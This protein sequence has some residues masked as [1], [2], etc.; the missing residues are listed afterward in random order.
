MDILHNQLQAVQRSLSFVSTDPIDWK[1]Y[2][3]V[4]AWSVTLFESY[5][6]C[7]VFFLFRVFHPFIIF[8]TERGNIHYI[9]KLSHRKLYKAILKRENLKNPKR[10]EKIRLGLPLCLGCINRHWIL[11]CY[12]LDSTRGRGRLLGAYWLSLDMVLNTRYFHF[13]LL[14]LHHPL[15][16][17]CFGRIDNTVDWVC[18]YLVLCILPSDATIASLW[19]VCFGR[20]TRFQQDDA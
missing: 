5:L 6:M 14:F 4:F 17:T 11:S 3:Q 7:V 2:V 13:F 12:N 1:F 8:L 10:M 9:L 19:N 16:L 15:E 18:I 20:K